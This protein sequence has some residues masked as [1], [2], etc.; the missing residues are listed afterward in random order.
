V[1]VI[2]LG[3]DKGNGFSVQGDLATTLML[4]KLLRATADQI[5]QD[6]R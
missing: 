1:V 5:E 6:M 2:V 4:P 3:G